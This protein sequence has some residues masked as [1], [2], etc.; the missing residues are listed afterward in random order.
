M[1]RIKELVERKD[2][3]KGRDR[4]KSQH[5]WLTFLLLTEENFWKEIYI[6]EKWNHRGK[7][8]HWMAYVIIETWTL[9]IVKGN[10]INI[11][12][13]TICINYDSVNSKCIVTIDNKQ[14]E[15]G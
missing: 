10:M 12:S 14:G 5:Y 4:G 2:K 6:H 11:Y 15:F 13:G 1:D 7:A 9:L 8:I 3:E